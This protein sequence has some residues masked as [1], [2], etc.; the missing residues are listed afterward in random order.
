MVWD[1]LYGVDEHLQPRRQMVESEEVSP[2]GLTWTFKLRPGL[3][4]H[5]GEKV[6][7][8]D[9]VASLDRWAVR[10]QMGLMLKAIEQDLGAPDDRTVKW[11]LK[12]PY[13]KMLL[14]LGKNNS[15][16]AFVMPERIAKTDPFKQISEYIGSGP[17]RFSKSEWV[18]GA[19]AVFE[20]FAGYVP[21]QEPAS[22]LA[23]GKRILIDRIEWI[24]M[25]DPGTASA[26]RACLLITRIIGARFLSNAGNGP[27]RFAISL[28]MW[29]PSAERI[30]ETPAASVRPASE[31][32]ARP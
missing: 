22:W 21:R 16:V 9:V 30:A 2:D 17:M 12:K 28:D 26:A 19:R 13:P 31:S 32:Y 6:L 11:V 1:T 15:P 27:I 14:A 3:T 8:K 23:G 5:D 25:P 24:V 20:K 10:D 29:Y 7:A 18:P 4:F